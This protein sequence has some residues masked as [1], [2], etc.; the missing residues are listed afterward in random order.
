M[1][2]YGKVT[3]NFPASHLPSAGASTSNALTWA[4]ERQAIERCVG[5]RESEHYF[6]LERAGA[7]ERESARARESGE[8]L[9]S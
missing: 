8:S 6:T 2:G 1:Y 3:M 7:G 4:K 9:L 5:E